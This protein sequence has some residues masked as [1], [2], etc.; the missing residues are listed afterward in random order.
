MITTKPGLTHLSEDQQDG[1]QISMALGRRG[2]SYLS[3]QSL[4]FE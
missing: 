2:L 1:S 3:I 4:L